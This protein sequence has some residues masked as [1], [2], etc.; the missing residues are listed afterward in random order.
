MDLSSLY[1]FSRLQP[2]QLARLESISRVRTFPKDSVLFYKGEIP[3]SLYILLEGR[4]RVYKHDHKGN[5]LPIHYFD[6]VTLVA[7]LPALEQIP[8]PANA[9]FETDG[10]VLDV[11]VAPFLEEFM[12]IPQIARRMVSSLAHKVRLLEAVIDRNLTK[13]ATARVAHLLTETPELFAKLT[14]KEIAALL[15]M[16]PETLSRTLAR[17]K[18]EG[19]IKGERNDWKIIDPGMLTILSSDA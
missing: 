7:E 12:A 6:P 8:Y 2:E 11:A 18:Q 13:D 4:V 19:W 5:E 9:T 3:A 14:Q 10:A 1:L 17:F 16:T 15:S